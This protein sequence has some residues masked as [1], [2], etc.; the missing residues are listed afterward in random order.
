MLKTVTDVTDAIGARS[1]P[2]RAAYLGRI[3]GARQDGPQRGN[4]NCGNLAHGFAGCSLPDK[5]DL[6]NTTKPNIAIVS[7]YNDMLSAHQPVWL[8][9]PNVGCVG[10]SWMVPHELVAARRWDAIG[11]LARAAAA[12]RKP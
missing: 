1:K 7:S 11:E 9:L 5:Q 8:A 6:G 2:M 10:G 4:L 12:P 3:A